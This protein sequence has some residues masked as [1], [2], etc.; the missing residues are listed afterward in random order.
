MKQAPPVFVFAIIVLQLL[1]CSK[2]VEQR[3]C[4]TWKGTTR[5]DQPMTITIRADST[6]QIEMEGDS[7][8][9]VRRG[10]YSIVDRR[11]R[12]KLTTTETIDG[13][14]VTR[15]D[16]TDQDE[17]TFVFTGENEMVLRKGLQAIVLERVTQ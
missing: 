3:L 10:T 13:D 16:K 7:G 5:I 2:S 9:V 17:A 14:R 12:I 8:R 1:G 6:I 11:L 4:G 15:E